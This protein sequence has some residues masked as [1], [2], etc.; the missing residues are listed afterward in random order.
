MFV[1]NLTTLL[2]VLVMILIWKTNLFLVALYVLTIGSVHFIYLTAVM[3]KFEQGGFLPIAFSF[4]LVTIMYV[5]NEVY[6][7][8]YYYELENKVSNHSLKAIASDPSLCRIPGLA[9]FYSELVQGIPPIFKQYVTNVPALNSVMVFVSIKSLPISTV[10]LEERFVFRRVEPKELS[11]FRCV[12][13]YGYNDEKAAERDLETMLV[14]RLKQFIRDYSWGTKPV[15]IPKNEAKPEGDSD[16]SDQE[17][18]IQEVKSVQ[19]VEEEVEVVEKAWEAGVV[20]F[21]GESEVVAAEGA[22]FIPRLMI[23]YIYSFLKRNV[24]QYDKTFDYIPHKRMLKVGM[25]YEL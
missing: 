18:E 8:K 2:L 14:E 16:G 21:I 1:I 3:Y 13:R 17:E 5:W 11:I 23:N 9:M 25:M 10:P 7:R 4:I 12:A 22:G 15:Q 19:S 24:R 20:H 6:K